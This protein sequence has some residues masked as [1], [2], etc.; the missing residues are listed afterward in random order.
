M[1]SGLRMVVMYKTTPTEMDAMLT[2]D[3][4][5]VKVIQQSISSVTPAIF[6]ESKLKSINAL[7]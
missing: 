4:T 6:E 2:N 5:Y 3:K 7:Y 1:K